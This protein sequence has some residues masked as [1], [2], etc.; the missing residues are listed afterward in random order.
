M[1]LVKMLNSDIKIY[2]YEKSEYRQKLK[3]TNAE[4]W[5]FYYKLTGG[6]IYPRAFY[7]PSNPSEIHILERCFAKNTLIDHEIG[8]I[9]GKDDTYFLPGVMNFTFLLRGRYD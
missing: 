1:K 2:E 9:E 7:M 4:E 8:H 3:E 5:C 6:I